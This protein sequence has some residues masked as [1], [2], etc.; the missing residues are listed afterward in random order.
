MEKKRVKN[1]KQ[2]VET[3]VKEAERV[4][5]T[6]ELSRPII[7]LPFYTKE[8]LVLIALAIIL[9]AVNNTYTRYLGWA[10]LVAAFIAPLLKE[11]MK[12]S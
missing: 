4:Y 1:T 3:D 9:V 6:T 2:A 8:G 10:V 5:E 11:M 12:K 7:L